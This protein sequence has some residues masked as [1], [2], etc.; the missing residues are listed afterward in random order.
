MLYDMAEKV[1]V[2]AVN[3]G[4]INLFKESS[5]AERRRKKLYL[6]IFSSPFCIVFSLINL[7]S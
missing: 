7:I 4:T 5:E 3:V 1:N 2:R 6:N